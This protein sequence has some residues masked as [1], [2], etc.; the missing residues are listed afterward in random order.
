MST[1]TVRRWRSSPFRLGLVRLI[2]ALALLPLFSILALNPSAAAPPTPDTV[3][4]AAVVSVGA[5]ENYSCKLMSDGAIICWGDDTAEGAVVGKTDPPAGSFTQLTVGV[6]HA[7]ALDRYHHAICWGWDAYD[8]LTPP[9]PSTQYRQISAGW[10]ETCA[11]E[12]ASNTLTCWGGGYAPPPEYADS[13]FQQV[14][15]G[16]HHICGMLDGGQVVCWGWNYAGEIVV[17]EAAQSGITQVSAGRDHTCALEEPWLGGDVICWGRNSEGQAPA[18]VSGPFTQV[19]A[20]FYHTCA[21]RADGTSACWG[22]N[23]DGRAT[24]P[25]GVFTQVSAGNDHSCGTRADGT[26][27]CWGDNTTGEV[28]LIELAPAALPPPAL[29]SYD[30]SQTLTASGGVGPYTFAL[31]QGALPTGLS[32]SPA[33]V[34]S[35]QPRGNGI[36]AFTIIATDENGHSGG[37]SYLLVVTDTLKDL[38]VPGDSGQISRFGWSIA[39]DGDRAAITAGSGSV[40]VFERAAGINQPWQQA[41]KLDEIFG[42]L[43]APYPTI[44][45][46]VALSGATLLAIGVDDVDPGW[47]LDGKI[48]RRD[49]AAPDGWRFTDE[50]RYGYFFGRA[51]D[52]IALEGDTLVFGNPGVDRQQFDPELPNDPPDVRILRRGLDPARPEDWVEEQTIPLSHTSVALSG[53]TLAVATSDATTLFERDG[54]G[55]TPWRQVQTLTCEGP[56]ALSGDTLLIGDS[57]H[58]QVH[59][60]HRNAGGTNNWGEAAPITRPSGVAADLTFGADVLLDGNVAVIQA[61]PESG[62]STPGWGVVFGHAP[63]QPDGWRPLVKL[64]NAVG[65]LALSG[66]TLLAPFDPSIDPFADQTREAV[67]AHWLQLASDLEVVAGANQARVIGALL[68]PAPQVRVRDINGDP[69]PH[70]A[71][72]SFFGWGPGGSFVEPVPGDTAVAPTNAAGI[73]TMPAYRVGQTAGAYAITVKLQTNVLLDQEAIPFTVQVPESIVHLTNSAQRT[74]INH[75]FPEPLQVRVKDSAGQPVA[76]VQVRFAVPTSGASAILSSA[77]ATTDAD[78]MA[79]VTAQANEVANKYQVIVTLPD[80]AQVPSIRFALYNLPPPQTVTVAGDQQHIAIGSTAPIT[81]EVELK[82]AAGDPIEGLHVTFSA[83]ASGP[84]GSFLTPGLVLNSASSVTVTSAATGV[85]TAPPFRANTTPGSY[86]ITITVEGVATPITLD[87]TNEFQLYL[88]LIRR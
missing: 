79:Q 49:P 28:T 24:P 33:G 61:P 2:G 54:S 3:S 64:F 82:D 84:G 22:H 12:V 26:S 45:R 53:T 5:G 76:G 73:A 88:Q 80:F 50:F 85:A 72:V 13:S 21:L 75:P 41:A 18:V 1:T 20:G 25:T 44:I 9:E 67:V 7:C 40:Y 42:S 83:P 52:V 31:T 43:D 66:Q 62:S 86:A 81:L 59:V 60:F 46:Q 47:Q 51:P 15:V 70:F 58:G 55:A 39:I 16:V 32:L 71:N 78:G 74:L 10:D 29:S 68:D 65:E 57:A 77:T 38:L 23:V 14:S 56:L 63:G 36:Y 17:P 37:R 30:Y 87:L 35:G 8:Q 34:L 27:A 6:H 48:Y 19:T 69:L 11:I 4:A